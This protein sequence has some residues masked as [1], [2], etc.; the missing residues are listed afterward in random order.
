MRCPKCGHSNPESVQFCTRCHM[1]LHFVCPACRHT[2]DHGGRCDK[3][4]VDFL[5]YAM[6]M[7]SQYEAQANRERS[8]ARGRNTLLKQIIL[9]P[10]TG[11][12]SL[13]KALRGK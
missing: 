7:H 3:C 1:T 8:R 13:L 2:Q 4:G 10:L 9:L 5:K 11:G 6:A 12:L